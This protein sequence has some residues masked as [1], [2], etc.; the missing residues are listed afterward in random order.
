LTGKDNDGPADAAVLWPLEM[1]R[2]GS[3]IGI[4]ISNGINSNYGLIDTYHMS[5]SAMDEAIRNAVAV[6]ADPG[7]IAL[8]DNFCWSSSDDPHRLAQ[9]VRACMALKDYSLTF[10][11]PFISGKDSMFNDYSGET[12]GKSIK[13]SVPPTLLISAIGLMPD[14]RKRVTMD[15]KKPGNLLY[16]IGSTYGELGGSEYYAM[17]GQ[18]QGK[19]F[20]GNKV[21]KVRAA[22]A[23]QRYHAINRAIDAGYIASC[24]DCSEGGIG[25]AAAEMAFSGGYGV[26]LDLSRIPGDRLRD[27]Y[28]LFSESQSRFMVE[29]PSRYRN[30]FESM[31]RGPYAQ[32]GKVNN[33]DYVMVRGASGKRISRSHLQDLKD[34]WQK[35]LGV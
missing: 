5:A 11:T 2:K 15:T 13:I 8:L 28:A 32:V 3:H 35:T 4:V 16:V 33:T 17:M 12:D 27:D 23:R 22:K 24:H 19:A 9:L 31:M 18:E 21:P 1:Q 25:V 6:G 29:V 7:R 14:I 10:G 26:S 34:A 20:I 30:A